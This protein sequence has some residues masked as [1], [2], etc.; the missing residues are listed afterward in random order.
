MSETT[1]QELPE[2]CLA[3]VIAFTTPRNAC[4][5]SLA[6]T[7]FHNSAKSDFVWDKFLPRD[8]CDIMSK[9]VSPMEFS[10]K[11]DL[12]FKLSTP[13]LIDGGSKVNTT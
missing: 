5:S 3:H 2:D 8:Y 11:K 12:F 9:L 10:S 7:M 4:H 6:S 1:I 13:L